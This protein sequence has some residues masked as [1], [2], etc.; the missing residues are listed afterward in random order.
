MGKKK[1]AK[2]TSKKKVEKTVFVPVKWHIPDTIITRFATNITVQMMES[3]FKISFF[4]QKPEM[5][6]EPSPPPSEVQAD[7]VASVIVTPDRLSRFIAVLQDQLD[8]YNSR[9]P[10]VVG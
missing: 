3:E 10:E 5:Y 4:E 6:F 7:C 1:T 9:P 2:K 8:K